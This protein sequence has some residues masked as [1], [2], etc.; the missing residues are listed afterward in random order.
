MS[1]ELDDLLADASAEPAAPDADG[2][3]AAGRRR[4][5]WLQAGGVATAAASIAVVGLVVVG[6]NPT[7]SPTVD[8]LAESGETAEP[9][10]MDD[11]GE[12]VPPSD[13]LPPM[14][15]PFTP[16]SPPAPVEEPEEPVETPSESAAEEQQEDVPAPTPGPQPD[17]AAVADPCAPHQDREMDAFI[18]VVSPVAGQQVGAT[19]ELVGCSNV[20]EANVRYRVIDASGAVLVDHFTTATCGTGCVGEFREVVPVSASG[21]VTVQVFWESPKD[22]GDE[23]LTEVVVSAG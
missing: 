16:A 6:V 21:E 9:A 14:E 19:I 5:R 17:A 12:A 18:D 8:P 22:G 13:E 20:P 11:A 15:R 1:A 2:L 4:R 3:W 10:P 23:D 7:P